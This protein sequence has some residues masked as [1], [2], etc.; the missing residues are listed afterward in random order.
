MYVITETMKK[1]CQYMLG[2]HFK[3]YI[4]QQSLNI[5]VLS[6]TIKPPKQQKWMTKL[7]GYNFQIIYKCG[8]H[9]VVANTLFRQEAPT[10]FVLLALSSAFFDHPPG[11]TQFHCTSKG[12]QLI[13]SCTQDQPL[14]NLF[15]VCQGL[16]FFRHKIFLPSPKDF[17]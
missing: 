6:Q 4:D 13:R 1:W 11:V 15:F 17:R 5:I 9:N 8:K 14:P 16:F 7:Q 3:I 12:Q 10:P 2:N